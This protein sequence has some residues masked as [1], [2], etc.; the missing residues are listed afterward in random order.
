MRLQVLYIQSLTSLLVPFE[1]HKG[2]SQLDLRVSTTW[3]KHALAQ[4]RSITSKNVSHV[5]RWYW[6]GD[7]KPSD[8]FWGELD[9]ILSADIF[10]S[11]IYVYVGFVS[12]DSGS[13][14]QW[15][16]SVHFDHSRISGLLPRVHKRGILS[17]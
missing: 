13:T 11:L 7:E 5:R 9:E 3:V 1:S 2:L 16:Y 8:D 14:T 4:L 10:K 17:Y 12:L 15:R 6:L